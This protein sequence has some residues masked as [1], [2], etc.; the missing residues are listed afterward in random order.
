MSKFVAMSKAEV[1]MMLQSKMMNTYMSAIIATNDVRALRRLSMLLK[2]I[3]NDCEYA[4]NML[5]DEDMLQIEANLLRDMNITIVNV[6]KED[7]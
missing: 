3:A 5:E 4:N 1:H 7:K 2:S 6:K